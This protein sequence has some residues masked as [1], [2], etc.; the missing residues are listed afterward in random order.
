MPVVTEIDALK[1]VDEAL[2]VLN[3]EE[4]VR[5][6][7][8]VNSKFLGSF[9]SPVQSV[10]FFA[11]KKQEAKQSYSETQTRQKTSSKAKSKTKSTR[12]T[13]TSYKQIKEL[14]LYPNEKPSAQDFVAEKQPTTKKQQCVVAV[15]Y[16]LEILEIDKVNIDHVYTFFKSCHWEL[17]ANLSNMMHQAG[18][19]GWLD[20]ADSEEIKLTPMG[21]NL[22]EHE[23]PKEQK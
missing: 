2:S 23:L 10:E 9:N 21:E 16:L 12:K 5:V 8:W 4:L 7:S 15:Y 1:T 20:T 19:A 13:K 22:V 17:P 14:N 6:L 18:S 3:D 11:P